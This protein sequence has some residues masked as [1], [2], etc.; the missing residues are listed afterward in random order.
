MTAARVQYRISV[1]IPC[2]HVLKVLMESGIFD[3]EEEHDLVIGDTYR[4][5]PRHRVELFAPAPDISLVVLAGKVLVD[6][7]DRLRIHL[8]YHLLNLVKEQVFFCGFVLLKA[9][10]RVKKDERSFGEMHKDVVEIV[11]AG[12]MG[13]RVLLEDVDKD[14]FLVDIVLYCLEVFEVAVNLL[15][16]LHVGEEFLILAS[17]PA[18]FYGFLQVLRRTPLPVF[19][20][21]FFRQHRD[22]GKTVKG[23]KCFHHVTDKIVFEQI[24]G[25]AKICSVHTIPPQTLI[26]GSGIKKGCEIKFLK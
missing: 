15:Q 23:L 25:I 11:T 20:L 26:F 10:I 2:E 1:G 22:K 4:T 19:R 5:A 9:D 7:Q 18:G 3:H 24:P 14:I 17:R 6:H 12:L 16:P 8:F 21:R 13:E